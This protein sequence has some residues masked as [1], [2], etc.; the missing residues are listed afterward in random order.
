VQSQSLRYVHKLALRSQ[1]FEQQLISDPRSVLLRERVSEAEIRLIESFAP[2]NAVA[3]GMAVEEVEKMLY[4][5]KN[6]ISVLN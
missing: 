3:F 6:D 4:N 2:Q 5:L 1:R